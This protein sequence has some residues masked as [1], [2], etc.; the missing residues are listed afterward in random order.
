MKVAEISRMGRNT[1]GVTLMRLDAD[2]KVVAVANIVGREEE[3]P[4]QDG[5]TKID[6]DTYFVPCYSSEA[7]PPCGGQFHPSKAKFYLQ[8]NIDAGG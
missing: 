7:V 5:E 4:A 3:P 2:D 8:R 1:Q 6:V